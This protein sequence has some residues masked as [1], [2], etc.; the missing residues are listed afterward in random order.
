MFKKSF[1]VTPVDL[2]APIPKCERGSRLSLDISQSRKIL[3]YP[4]G[5]LIVLR[6][7]PEFSPCEVLQ[8]HR[9]TVTAVRFSPSSA[10]LASGDESGII[11]IWDL[12]SKKEPDTID[13][14]STPIIEMCWGDEE[15]LIV[16]TSGK[17]MLMM[18]INIKKKSVAGSMLHHTQKV[19][20]CDC[21]HTA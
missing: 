6:Q 9:K 11:K 10:L 18:P 21:T 20:C 1:T 12:S 5:N 7:L 16:S 3:A 17:G 14:L 15:N 8:D 13:M 2:Y 4:S 19:A